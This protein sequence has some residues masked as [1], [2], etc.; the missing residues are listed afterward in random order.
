MSEYDFKRVSDPVHNTI[1]LSKVELAVIGTSAFQRL[2]GVKQLGLASLVFP[3]ADYSRFSHSL[4]VCHVTGAILAALNRY[5]FKIDPREVQLYRLAGLLHDVGHYP[6]SHTTE[7]AIADHYSAEFLEPKQPNLLDAIEP[8]PSEPLAKPFLDHESVGKQ[9]LFDNAELRDV[10]KGHG[11]EPKEVSSIF[12]REDPAQKFRNLVSS[13]LDAD[14]IDYLMRTA[15]HSGL[16]Y[17]SI[18]LPYL[19]TQ[20]KIDDQQRI[21]IEPRAIRAAD[22]VLLCRYFDYTQ[23]AYHKTVAAFEEMLKDVTRALLVRGELDF[24]AGEISARLKASKWANFNDAFLMSRIEHL[25]HE[26]G[27]QSQVLKA[28]SIVQRNPP[29]L[30]W[31]RQVL[32]DREEAK[33]QISNH[34]KLINTQIATWSAKYGIPSDLWKVWSAGVQLTK[35]GARVRSSLLAVEDKKEL[36]RYEQA[37]RVLQKDGSSKEIMAHKSSLMSVLS[38][39]AYSAVRLYAI[40]PKDNLSQLDTIRAEV[41]TFLDS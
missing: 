19:L 15:R 18:D 12:L 38:E 41:A 33:S 14:R 22:H 25:S 24:S 36:D 40:V 13:D 37:V 39:K 16:P 35:V 1:G 11:Y 7:H 8:K 29:K 26:G 6:F 5:G 28:Q 32:E 3:G 4:G 20:L 23:V 9:L 34:Q 27:K 10:L 30:I 31:E 17:S 2:R 21:C